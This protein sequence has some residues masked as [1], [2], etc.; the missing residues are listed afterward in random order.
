MLTNLGLESEQRG[1]NNRVRGRRHAPRDE[2]TGPQPAYMTA[3]FAVQQ[4]PSRGL[5]TAG[6][7]PIQEIYIN[8][9][10]EY[11][12]SAAGYQSLSPQLRQDRLSKGG[13]NIFSWNTDAPT[14]PQPRVTR[15]RDAGE[16]LRLK[17][18]DAETQRDIEV[19]EK[20]EGNTHGRFLCFSEDARDGAQGKMRVCV[21]ADS[22]GLQKALDFGHPDGIV[23]Q[24]DMAP[25]GRRRSAPSDAGG[26]GIA[27]F[28]GMGMNGGGRPYNPRRDAPVGY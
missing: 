11:V 20:F 28:A 5:P 18:R 13:L 7:Q 26:D 25:R 12:P 19:R 8:N 21:N 10:D 1:R 4:E 3:P 24:I 23:R 14:A 6:D 2:M 16:L 15:D 17:P 22:N 9:E 27:G